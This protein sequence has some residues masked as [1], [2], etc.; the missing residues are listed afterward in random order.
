M[1]NTNYVCFHC[2]R[3]VRRPKSHMAPSGISVLCPQCGGRTVELSYKIPLPPKSKIKAWQTLHQQLLSERD[4]YQADLAYRLTRYKHELEREIAAIQQKLAE[5]NLHPQ[6]SKKLRA[7][8][9]QKENEYK[10]CSFG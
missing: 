7:T 10:N 3:A 9:K 6:H 1:S 5:A 8:L 4:Q 2:R